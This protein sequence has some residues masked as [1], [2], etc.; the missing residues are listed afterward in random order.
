[1]LDEA[2]GF[3]KEELHRAVAQLY[4]KDPLKELSII[5][6][7]A[8]AKIAYSLALDVDRRVNALEAVGRGEWVTIKDAQ[9]L[10]GISRA[11]IH[12]HLKKGLFQKRKI[13]GRTYVH[14]WDASMYLTTVGRFRPQQN[15]VFLQRKP[16]E[17]RNASLETPKND[18][19][20]RC[21]PDG[22]QPEVHPEPPGSIDGPEPP[23]AV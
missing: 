18:A 21:G 3:S 17:S 2:L 10:L 15:K 12:R 6:V 22:T 23:A 4:Y 19:D 20:T 1:M 13:G 5:D 14:G 11:T 7:A 8:V 16:D 9:N